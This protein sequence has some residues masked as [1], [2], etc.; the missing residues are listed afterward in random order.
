MLN[1]ATLSLTVSLGRKVLFLL[2]FLLLEAF[3]L[4]LYLFIYYHAAGELCK[5]AEM[6][7]NTENGKI[8]ILLSLQ[9]SLTP[10]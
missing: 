3:K 10:Q 6:K 5:I 2:M 7:I 8:N 4:I 1:V 9:R